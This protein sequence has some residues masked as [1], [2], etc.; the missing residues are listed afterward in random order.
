VTLVYELLR[1]FAIPTHKELAIQ[2]VLHRLKE[3]WEKVDQ[4][5]ISWAIIFLIRNEAITKVAGT[6]KYVSTE[7]G[8]EFLKIM[9]LLFA[10]WE[11]NKGIKNSLTTHTAPP[12][13]DSASSQPI[14]LAAWATRRS[15]FTQFFS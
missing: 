15:L 12:K 9:D 1:Q 5:K 4:D 11:V 2:G 3:E 8:R 7:I 6:E 13:H 14:P 10:S